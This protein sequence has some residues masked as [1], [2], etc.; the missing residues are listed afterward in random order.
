MGRKQSRQQKSPI[1]E[2]MPVVPSRPSGGVVA[3]IRSRIIAGLLLV[4]P[5]FVT[6]WIVYWLYQ[7]LDDYVIAPVARIVV[8]LAEGG[9][10]AVPSWFTTWVAPIVGLITVGLMLYFLGFFARSRL[11]SFVDN[12]VL[13]VPI[14]TSI[15]S[16]TSR[17]FNAL[18]GGDMSKFKRVVLVAFPQPGMRSPGF[19]TSSCRDTATGRTILCVYVPTTP[20]PTSGYMLMVPEEEVTELD[21]TLEE[22]IQAVVSFG[23]TAPVEVQYFAKPPAGKAIEPRR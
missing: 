16:A 3:N 17:M 1:A 21:W 23:L 10:V 11:A 6:F 19:V 4:L 14:V 18:G 5:F 22:T 9:A 7:T 2:P 13:R 20:I 12:F 8:R 15:Y